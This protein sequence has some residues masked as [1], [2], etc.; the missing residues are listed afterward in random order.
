M[1]DHAILFPA[2]LVVFCTLLVGCGP[3]QVGV[4]GTVTVDGAP[5]TT[6]DVSYHP[7]NSKD[8]S[9]KAVGHSPIDAQGKY[10]LFTDGNPGVP[11]GSYK[12]VVHASPPPDAANPYAVPAPL[13]DKKYTELATTPLTVEVAS[14]NSPDKYNLALT[15]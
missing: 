1:R 10:K 15:K 8:K 3:N 5:L 7:V 12:V 13:I 4:E 11:P 14:G 2:S 6:G 9:D